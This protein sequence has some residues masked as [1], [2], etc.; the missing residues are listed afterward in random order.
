MK[1]FQQIVERSF[2]LH[3]I[4]SE[5]VDCGVSGRGAAYVDGTMTMAQS[6]VDIGNCSAGDTGGGAPQSHCQG[7]SLHV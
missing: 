2:H 4:S 7:L 3:V 6:R 5:T 1:K